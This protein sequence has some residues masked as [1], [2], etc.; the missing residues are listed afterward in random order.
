MN[1]ELKLHYVEEVKYQKGQLIE[2]HNFDGIR[3]LDNPPPP[4]LMYIFYIS[5]LFS[6]G[7]W[8]YYRP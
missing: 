1:K 3:E 6:I 8:I 4:W 2:S 7:Y 5:V